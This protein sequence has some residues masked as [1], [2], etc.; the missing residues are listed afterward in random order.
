MLGKFGAAAHLISTLVE[1]RDVGL[2]APAPG[3]QRRSLLRD[4]FAGAPLAIPAVGGRCRFGRVVGLNGG[5][6]G[7]IS[8]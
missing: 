3:A 6:M 4:N 5:A 8:S 1:P 7:S 2:Q